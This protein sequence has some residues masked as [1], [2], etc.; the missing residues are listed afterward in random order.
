MTDLARSRRL[1]FTIL[2]IG[3]MVCV[4]L[5]IY[6][7][8][9]ENRLIF[10][11]SRKLNGA[12]RVPFENVAFTADD[13]TR[14]SGWLIPFKESS[15]VFVISHGNA[16]NIGDR[17][18]MGE[19]VHRQF[20]TNVFMYDYRGYG[21]SDGSPSE[22]GLYSDL[23]GA[24]LYMRSRGFD[25]DNTFLIGQSLGTAVVVD[26]ATREQV[27]GIILEAPFTSVAAVARKIV[28]V[29]IG[30]LFSTRFDSLS[31]IR[32]VKAPVVVIHATNDP[33]IPFEL[34]LQ[35]FKAIV[36][37][38]KMFSIDGPFHE[39][40]MTEMKPAEISEIRAFLLS[41]TK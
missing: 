26:V 2:R 1:G 18:E 23:Q 36:G 4:G 6:V 22:S 31:K 3:L 24:L 15:Q 30:F 34:G 8:L 9:F 39:G 40:V 33:V 19:F 38:K 29:P 35:L 27:A 25:N 37:P 14:L 11:P 12:P 28:H 32:E 7:K 5:A 16:G 20:R 10:Y 17:Y 21:A 41:P 13:G